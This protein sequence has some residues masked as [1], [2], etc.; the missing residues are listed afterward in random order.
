MTINNILRKNNISKKFNINT[1]DFFKPIFDVKLAESRNEIKL[2]QKLRYKVFFS[3]RIHSPILNIGNFR[4]D[5]D[6]FDNYADH[7]IVKFRKSKFSKARVIGTY[8]LLKQSVADKKSGFYSCDEFNLDNLLNSKIYKNMLELSRSCISQKFRNKNVL[9]LMWN[10]IYRYINENN[11]DALFGTASF[12]DTNINKIEDQLIYLNN[13]YKMSENIKVNALA[14][15]KVKVDYEKKIDINL[16]LVSRLP[17]LIKAYLKFN[18]TIGEGAVIDKKFKTTDV[19]VFLP[20]EEINK[21]Y[22][23]KIIS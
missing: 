17:T 7:I 15:Y 6:K 2:A 9:K 23:N 14:N 16:K 10:E 3:E 12:L 22:V 20:I 8:R 11:I 13:N 19:F 21:D 5:S 4:R 18:A 1:Y